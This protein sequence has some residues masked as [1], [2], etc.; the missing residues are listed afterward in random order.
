MNQIRIAQLSIFNR[1]LDIVMPQDTSQSSEIFFLLLL[2]PTSL[3]AGP[4]LPPSATT[5]PVPPSLTAPPPGQMQVAAGAEPPSA[6]GLPPPA[7]SLTPG[8]RGQ[9]QCRPTSHHAGPFLLSPL[10]RRLQGSLRRSAPAGRA[11]LP[12]S[13]FHRGRVD[14]HEGR[15]VPADP[16]AARAYELLAASFSAGMAPG[17][18]GRGLPLSHPLSL[19]LKSTSMACGSAGIG[20]QDHGE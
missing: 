10:M 18:A 2:Y 4:F 11:S 1:S 19:S 9:L 16:R 17:G 13:R 12:P 7:P 8:V 20:A 6:P 15:D 5:R 3:P 14:P